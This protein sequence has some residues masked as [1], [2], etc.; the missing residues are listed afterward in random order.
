MKALLCTLICCLIITSV[1]TQNNQADNSPKT[2]NEWTSFK[3][4]NQKSAVNLMQDK[5]TLK[6]AKDDQ[7]I[8]SSIQDDALGFRH[9]RYQQTYKDIPIEGAIYLMH[10]KNN[11]VQHANGKLVRKLNMNITP[12]I[13]ETAALQSALQHINATLYAWD[14]PTH[15]NLKKQIE[16]CEDA[17]FYPSGELVI[18]DPKFSNKTEQYRLAYKFDVYAVEPLTRS[19]VYID[20][21]NSSIID[22]VE[23]IHDCTN[24]NA[25]GTTNYS[26]N[27][28]FTACQENDGTH[29]LKNNTGGGMQVFN[30]NNTNGN[31]QLPFT[32]S[33]NF[34]DDDPAANEVH[35][36]TEK[37]YNYFFQTHNRN[38]LD[39]NNMPLYSWIHYRENLNNAFWN[40]SWMTYGD[41]DN[42][43]FSSL[44]SP[45][46]VA[47][48]MT[49][50]VTDFSADL[51]YR[52]ESGALNESFSDIFGEVAENY[53]RGSN[54]WLIGG[55]FTVKPGK[56]CLRNMSNPNDPNAIAQQPDTYQG[57]FW[58]TIT[59]NCHIF[60]DHCGVHYN[61]GVQNY[62]FYLLSEGGS[63]I[64]DDDEEYLVS[65]IGMD[66]AAAIAY[67]NLTVYLTSDSQYADA[68]EGAIQ[69]AIDLY[70]NSNEVE[71]VRAAWCAVGVG[72][73]CIATLPCRERDS[74]ALV[75]VYNSTNG[76]NWTST[77]DLTQEID[78]WDGVILNPDGCVIELRLQ[79]NNL[80]GTMPPEIG[81][82]SNLI[83]LLLS[84]NQLTGNIPAELGN[85]SNLQYLYLND[86]QL[87]GNIPS[88]LQDAGNLQIIYLQ[89]N[90]LTGSIPAEFSNL[91]N[92]E[93]LLLYN[94]E[95]SG[96]Y[97]EN[98][99]T[100]CEQLS[101]D[102]N[103]NTYISDGNNFDVPWESF[104][105]ADMGI[106]PPILCREADSLALVAL[107]NSTDG[108]NW[109]TIWDLSQPMETWNGVIFNNQGCVDKLLLSNKNLNGVIPPELGNLT[110]LR[111]LSLIINQLNG[112]I[113]FE[114]GNLM[115]LQK[116]SLGNN[117]LNGSIPSGLENLVNLQDLS[118]PYNQLNG[119]IPSE[120]GN[121]INLEKLTLGNNQ[122][123]GG[124]P[125]E[126]GN[127]DNLSRLNLRDN[128]LEGDI[129]LEIGNLINLISLNL[130]GNNLTGA[131]LPEIGNLTK[132]Y[133]L[134]LHNNQFTGSIPSEIG[135]LTDLR[136]VFMNGNDL[137]GTIPVEIGNLNGLEYLNLSYNEL[138]GSIIPEI[139]NL[140]YLET[141]NLTS[142]QLSGN[143]PPEIGNLT[144]LMR[145]QIDWNDLTGNIPAELGDL[146]NLQ[147]IFAGW[148]ELNGC[149][150]P[151]LSNLCSQLETSSNG[152]I[153]NGNDFDTT[154]EDF[155]LNGA[156][157]CDGSMLSPVWPGDFNNDGMVSNTDILQWGL[158]ENSSGFVR[159]NATT[160]WVAQDCP[161]WQSSI[162][163][164]NLKHADGNGDG[165]VNT[166]DISVFV[167]NYGSTHTAAPYSPFT[168]NP[169]LF[170]LEPI[171]S[172][173]EGGFINTTYELYVA[174][175]LGIPVS[176][177]GVACSIDFGSLLVNSIDVNVDSSALVPH[178]HIGIFDDTQ[179]VLDIALTRTDK[180]NQLCDHAIAQI[181]VTSDDI[182]SG[183][184]FK[185]I[186][187][188]SKTMSA[189]GTLTN[190]IGSVQ[191]GFL[192]M[193]GVGEDFS[194]SV[195]ATY[196][197]CNNAGEATVVTTGGAAPYTYTWSTGETTQ[198]ITNLSI[199][200]HQV[201]VTD[202]TGTSQ[203]IDFDIIWA[204]TPVEA[205]TIN[206]QIC[207]SFDDAPL[208]E[209]VQI[210]LDGGIT[211][212]S[213]VTDNIC[214][215][216][217]TGS[218]HV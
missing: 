195:T 7:L 215:N 108:A 61:S 46:V 134:V 90:Q 50:G 93:N 193:S 154:W 49:H 178:E 11:R 53:M 146:N 175:S 110:N 183:D 210:S 169:L 33:D 80:V 143:I 203:T 162:N 212:E 199:G 60:N 201:T 96:C 79:D 89:D 170:R 129:P 136:I 189:N 51:V 191:Y 40:G 190:V 5:T 78:T 173:I 25:S 65:G 120:L 100:L 48:E 56:N 4:A 29:I 101:P 209:E 188:G 171:S 84:D 127:L 86:N 139:G 218:Y 22:T 9:Y 115:S 38:S 18:I 124:I 149:Y 54:D 160:D 91:N 55:D 123:S 69:A 43:R 113:P 71:Q 141:L 1:Y 148:N 174:S 24:V 117:Q 76:N 214:Y 62:W 114:L 207:I 137:T 44:T 103:N 85:L 168:E 184:P 131:I 177:H 138:N 36:A 161:D 68:R 6:L 208:A 12:S 64:N 63:G 187:G 153:S 42:Q 15:E 77:W 104:C 30:S 75:A 194:A 211:Y 196:S 67:R 145:L 205:D 59:E 45:D 125:P 164:I 19:I 73:S 95:L 167:D 92:L 99:M 213:P 159:P 13:S 112:N 179:N 21:Q 105:D 118:L 202:A 17:T 81:E 3:V 121:L 156:G 158:A 180:N 87:T 197:Q 185:F 97:D 14:D 107:Y 155:C 28:S 116:L 135:N 26:G 152:F 126:L 150:H 82:L 39:N 109:T 8:L 119:S 52:A 34:F 37:T 144:S 111:E 157:S 72:G 88:E 23:K 192:P 70:P 41:G 165:I 133:S 176:T 94:N 35:W 74:L 172:V 204:F 66:K 106:C 58:R 98:L 102:Y 2:N 47:H 83:T 20:A 163:D 166:D 32:D 198:Q 140:S 130:S 16:S 216:V 27:Q 57:D 206:K 132:L 147:H 122:L 200:D 142:N 31:P 128:N 151:N 10:E 186:I 182:Q 181:I 217:S